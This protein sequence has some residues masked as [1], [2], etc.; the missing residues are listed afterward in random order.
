MRKQYR[1][2]EK[3]WYRS[4]LCLYHDG[5]GVSVNIY[6]LHEIYDV[7]EGVESHGY[8]RGYTKEEIDSAKR[9]YE[10]KLA[11]A[12]SQSNLI[13]RCHKCIHE[14]FCS[15]DYDDENKCP[16]YKKDPPDGGSY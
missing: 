4:Y 2:V 11:N 9:D 13:P 1:V 7:I 6:N 3:D 5:E 8:T 16:R 14:E 10:H 12:I 15:K